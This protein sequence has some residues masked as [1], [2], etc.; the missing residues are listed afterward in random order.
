VRTCS[1]V[2]CVGRSSDLS[3]RRKPSACVS[4]R[5]TTISD[6]KWKVTVAGRPHG[7]SKPTFRGQVVGA[8]RLSAPW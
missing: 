4:Q 6:P 5:T 1:S 7:V 3:A 8:F 2:H